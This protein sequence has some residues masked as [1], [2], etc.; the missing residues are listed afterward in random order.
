MA[1]TFYTRSADSHSDLKDLDLHRSV[2]SG[3]RRCDLRFD[4]LCARA[5][6]LHHYAHHPWDHAVFHGLKV[7]FFG[8]SS[9]PRNVHVDSSVSPDDIEKFIKAFENKM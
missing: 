1:F 7:L 3:L 8:H 4:L 5:R 9:P 2:R 6:R